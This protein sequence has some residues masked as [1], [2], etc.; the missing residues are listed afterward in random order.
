[1]VSIVH[2][3]VFVE[4]FSSVLLKHRATELHREVN[5]ICGEADLYF[6]GISSNHLAAIW[7]LL[8]DTV[9]GVENNNPLK[10]QS[11]NFFLSDVFFPVLPIFSCLLDGIG[12]C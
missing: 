10:C 8:E 2:M 11:N 4:R 5:G 12:I 9:F 3:P 6:L 1:M 7:T